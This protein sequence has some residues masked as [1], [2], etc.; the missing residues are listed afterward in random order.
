MK[1]FRCE[2]DIKNKAYIFESRYYCIDCFMPDD[3]D[4]YWHR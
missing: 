1:C 3:G 2:K 4:S